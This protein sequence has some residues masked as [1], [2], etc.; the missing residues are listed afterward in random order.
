MCLK[1]GLG[2]DNFANGDSYHG[3]YENGKPNGKGEYSWK[4]GQYYVGDFL[5]GKKHGKGKW[6]S[7]KSTSNC[8]TYDGDY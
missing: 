3:M 1:H 2:T 4:N 5:K 7:N 8:N 6:K